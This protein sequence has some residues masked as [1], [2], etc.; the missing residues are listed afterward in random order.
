MLSNNSSMLCMIMI[1]FKVHKEKEQ[2][3]KR[4]MFSLNKKG[5][6]LYSVPEYHYQKKNYKKI[7]SAKPLTWERED[8]SSGS[9]GR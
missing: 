8:L 6:T 5:N 1:S 2:E 3:I 4:K 9:V 7:L